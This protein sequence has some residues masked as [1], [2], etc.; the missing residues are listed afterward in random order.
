MTPTVVRTF[1]E[2]EPV[3]G[4]RE[5]LLEAGFDRDR[6]QMTV[7][8]AETGSAE[9]DFASGNGAVTTGGNTAFNP[10][11]PSDDPYRQ[12]YAPV[13]SGAVHL[14]VVAV[15]NDAER[16]RAERAIERFGGTD[17]EA[18]TRSL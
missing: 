2:L 4:A 6:I 10:K 16:E 9:G 13:R 5:A 3:E 1:H 7:L 18:R 15:I 8:Q 12:N 11:P 17:V 14:L